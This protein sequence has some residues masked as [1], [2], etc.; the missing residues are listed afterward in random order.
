MLYR[1]ELKKRAIK[2]NDPDHWSTFKREINK[3]N[4]DVKKAKANYFN[5]EITR[6]T[7]N[8]KAIWNSINQLTHRKTTGDSSITEIKMD[9]NSFTN[10]SDISEILN[11]H[12]TSI[13]AKLTAELPD[14]GLSFESYITSTTSTLCLQ[15]TTVD[16]VLKLLKKISPHKA[17]GLDDISCRLLKEAAP[18]I[19]PHLTAIINKSIDT[20]IFPSCWKTAK[21]FPLHKSN[22]RR[23]PQNYRPISVLP[24][25]SKVCERIIYDQ[26][27]CYLTKHKLLTKYQSGFRPLHSTVTALLDA[28]NEWYLNID[29][30]MT[31]LAVFLDLAKA[32]DTVSHHILLK[33]LNMYGIKGRTHDWFSSYL[34]NRMQQCTVEGCFSKPLPLSCGVPQGSILGPLLFIIY[35]NDLPF[36]LSNSKPRMYA[37]DTILSASAVSSTELFSKMNTDLINIRNWLLANKLSLNVTKTEYMLF[38]STHRLSN[39]GKP[40]ILKIGDEEIK[41]VDKTKYL[42]MSLDEQL[43]WT[44]HI[45]Q[46]CL[47]VN[48]SINGLKQA[49]HYVPT[50]TLKLMYN[51]LIQPTFD[52][53]DTVYDSLNAGLADQLQKLQNRA[54]RIITFQGYDTR[55]QEI[56]KQLNWENLA[57][58]RE[59]RLGAIMYDIINKHAPT[60]LSDLFITNK[61]SNVYKSHLRENA[62]NINLNHI[63]KTEYFKHSF[64]YRGMKNWN[65]LPTTVKL[66]QS[67]AIFKRRVSLVYEA[68]CAGARVINY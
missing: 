12:F 6:N 23:D 9:G 24:A 66:S 28:T 3:I 46:L 15:H 67:K 14:E 2:T 57:L 4:N 51:A 40:N 10:P 33:K 48:R 1:D 22:D 8:P 60:Y 42:G 21:V 19:A 53:C 65:S 16:E 52:Y 39:L 26:L 17:T 7:G 38:G 55:S 50:D 32:F 41:R 61:D 47:R 59:K 35:I 44:E 68:K 54:A 5:S 18:I 27:Y 64:M 58:R 11:S 43:T 13:G 30:G 20:G 63:P 62:L 49:R 34:S 36:S 37:D 45:E 56:L 29:K 31:N 25:V